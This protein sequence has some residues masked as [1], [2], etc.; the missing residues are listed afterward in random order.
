MVET[1]AA[2]LVLDR[3]GREADFFSVGSNDLLQYFL[4]V[5]RGNASAGATSTIRCTRPSC[6]CCARRP[7]RPARRNAGWASAAKWPEIRSSC[8]CWSGLGFDELSMASSRIPAVKERLRQLD[9]ARVPRPAAPRP[10]L[11]RS[12]GKSR[13]LLQEFN[14]R[15]RAGRSDR[16]GT[17]PPGL[18]EP[19]R[20]RGHQ[21]TLR[22][23][24]AR[25]PG[26]DASALEE[27]VWKREE[28]YATDLG[29][30]FALPHGKSTAVRA[31]PSPSCA[32]AGRSA[33]AG[34]PWRRCGASC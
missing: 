7:A 10:A 32:R 12:A 34:R 16:A 26:A 18:G 21:G 11:R 2:A 30:G 28:T 14:G 23:A 20:R 13:E 24:G 17:D 4:A 6:A 27:A 5:D 15:G 19:H 31:A 8:R 29:F 1:P 9:S 33:G 3:L 22:H 25:R